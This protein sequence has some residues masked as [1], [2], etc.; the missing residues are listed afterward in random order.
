MRFNRR[1]VL[2]RRSTGV[3]P[4]VLLFIADPHL[5]F[6]RAPGAVKAF[7]QHLATE[8]QLAEAM[9]VTGDV[10]EAP[11]VVRHLT[12]L[13]DGFGKKIFFLA[14]NHDFYK[15]S[16]RGVHAALAKLNEPNLVWLD[17]ADP[18]LF[19]EFALVGK[20]A[21]YDG[22]NGNP[23]STPIALY[24]FSAIGEFRR[25]YNEYDW[26]FLA[27]HG[28]RNPL[29]KLLRK[30]AKEAVAEARTKLEAALQ[31]RKH[32]I[33]ATHVA[34]FEE[35]A[36]HEGK[37]SDQDWQ[38]W[39]SC[40]QMGEMLAEVAPL[41]PEHKILVLCGHSHS[42]GVYQHVPNLRVVTGKAEYGFPDVAGVLTDPFD[43]WPS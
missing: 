7:G 22:L 1:S 24:D 35:A 20:F 18:V 43:G 21:W 6:L 15:G 25:L 11:T 19:D 28:S 14:G 36:W 9:I 40:R 26:E 30:L 13:A 16:I 2:G 37:I 39:F 10:S 5:N 23:Q 17:T 38:P 3:H 8:Y 12:E 42:P 27:D 4:G 34:P 41:H 33:F 29:L 31:L 32:V